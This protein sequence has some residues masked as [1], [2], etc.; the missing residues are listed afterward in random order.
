MFLECLKNN[1]KILS[2]VIIMQFGKG[3]LLIIKKCLNFEP[4]NNAHV[5]I[6]S[7]TEQYVNVSPS[8]PCCTV[9]IN[10]FTL[11]QNKQFSG[12]VHYE[13]AQ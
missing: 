12:D 3:V 9:V 5:H 1:S 13:K 7:L 10:I 2:D 8:M 11:H 4:N 6:F